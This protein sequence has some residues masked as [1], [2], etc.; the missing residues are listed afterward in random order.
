M[1]FFKISLLTALLL[2]SFDILAANLDFDKAVNA[3]TA[4][5]KNFVK[6]WWFFIIIGLSSFFIITDAGYH[7]KITGISISLSIIA[8]IFILYFAFT[9]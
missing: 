2:M 8:S 7:N 3:I 5:Y 1:R 6:D 9:W 4:P